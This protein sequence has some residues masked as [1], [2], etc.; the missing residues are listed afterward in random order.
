MTEKQEQFANEIGKA[1]APIIKRHMLEH[2]LKVSDVIYGCVSEAEEIALHTKR[3]NK[4]S[5]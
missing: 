1:I 5:D 2:D 3:K 4:L